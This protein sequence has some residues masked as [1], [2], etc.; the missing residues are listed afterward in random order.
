MNIFMLDSDPALAAKYHC[1]RHTTKMLV[2]Y[3]QLM[4]TAHRVID[5][6]PNGVGPFYRA[7]HKNHPSAVWV[8]ESINNYRWLYD[9]WVFLHRE[10]QSRYGRDH[11][12]FVR[13][14]E[15]LRQ[16]PAGI[17]QIDGT[18]LRLA[19][20]NTAY[21]RSTPVESYR[22]YYNGDKARFARWKNGAI[23]KWFSGVSDV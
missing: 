12:S 10:Y 17:P 7:T 1:D 18:P 23:P 2:E 19:I 14:S 13:L 20:A 5:D 4:S 15:T 6:I 22:A 21:H 16:P 9:L 3:A 11:A 8:R